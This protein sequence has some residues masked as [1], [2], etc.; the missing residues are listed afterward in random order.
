MKRKLDWIL[1]SHNVGLLLEDDDVIALEKPAGLLVLPDRFD[2]HK[3]NLY[4]LLA[5]ELGSI[6]VV[7]RID[8]ETSGIIL[9]A[10]TAESHAALNTQFET[11]TVE[12]VYQGL[13]RGIPEPREGTIDLALAESEREPAKMRVVKRGGKP[14]QTRYQVVE[15]FDGYALVELRPQTGRTHQLRV[16]LAA[17]GHPIVGDPLYGDGQPFYLSSV[18]RSYRS[19]DEEKPLLRRT[20]LHAWRLAFLHPGTGI[21][22]RLEADLPKDLRSTVRALRK[23]AGGSSAL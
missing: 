8:R 21:Q 16:H 4:R 2:Q 14:S 11:R 22:V 17:V 23:Y 12:K 19:T 18:K 10:K 5:E 3:P 7:H 20:A 13:V 1:R 15:V 9:F 6:F